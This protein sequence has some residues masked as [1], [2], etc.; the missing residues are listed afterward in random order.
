LVSVG[1]AALYL[2]ASYYLWCYG[3]HIAALVR[4]GGMRQL[5]AAIVAQKSFWKLVGITT[6]V[7]LALYAVLIVLAVALGAAGAIFMRR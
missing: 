6:A 7:M 3:K 5:Q 4:S 1:I 2:F